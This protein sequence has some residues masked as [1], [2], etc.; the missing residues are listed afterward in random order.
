MIRDINSLRKAMCSISRFFLLFFFQR[1]C[2][3][4]GNKIDLDYWQACSV[5][6]AT[7]KYLLYHVLYCKKRLN[8]LKKKHSKE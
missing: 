3:Q 8:R 4:G 7:V 6:F 2:T 5:V 1:L